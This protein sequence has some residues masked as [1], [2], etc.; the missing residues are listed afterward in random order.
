MVY[1]LDAMG[2]T[3][4][5]WDEEFLVTF[6]EKLTKCCHGELKQ[7]GYGTILVSFFLE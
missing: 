6:K 1:A 4:F 5:N 3:I 7:F 2:P